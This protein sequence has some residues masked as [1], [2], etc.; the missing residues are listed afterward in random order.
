MVDSIEAR[1]SSGDSRKT[2]ICEDG[3]LT[4]NA[5]RSCPSNPLTWFSL[6]WRIFYIVQSAGSML[7]WQITKYSAADTSREDGSFRIE[8]V[9]QP[10]PAEW[11]NRNQTD[12]WQKSKCT[13]A[14]DGVTGTWQWSQRRRYFCLWFP[15]W[16][17]WISTNK[18][19]SKL[20]WAGKCV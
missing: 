2:G 8:Q 12:Q 10:R 17:W 3:N 4:T 20:I 13:D 5:G 19:S 7:V 15:G 18:A 14:D 11:R 1:C 16:R 6:L 9:P